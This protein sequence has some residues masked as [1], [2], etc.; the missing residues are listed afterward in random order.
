MAVEKFGKGQLRLGSSGGCLLFQKSARAI[1]VAASLQLNRL[2][3]RRGSER[4]RCKRSN[5]RC[6]AYHNE[7]REPFAG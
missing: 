2:I 3:G 1:Q 6:S 7:G 5:Q 4:R